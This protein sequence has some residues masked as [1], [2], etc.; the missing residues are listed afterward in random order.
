MNQSAL[1]PLV[2]QAGVDVCNR[3]RVLRREHL[4]LVTTSCA[5]LQREASS[6]ADDQHASGFDCYPSR[7]LHSLCP[8]CTDSVGGARCVPLRAR[9]RSSRPSPN[10]LPSCYCRVQAPV[11]ELPPKPGCAARVRNLRFKV[12]RARSILHQF[13]FNGFLGLFGDGGGSLSISN[14][15]SRVVLDE[16]PSAGEVML[17]TGTNQDFRS[18]TNVS[19]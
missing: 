5:P 14:G 1:D 18:L 8:Q 15:G 16:Q 10:R 4:H 19:I 12:L 9:V 13:L 7:F 17:G 11:L 2:D 3:R 6:V